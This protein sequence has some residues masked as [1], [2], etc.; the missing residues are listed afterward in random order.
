LRGFR[1]FFLAGREENEFDAGGVATVESSPPIVA[2][3][4]MEA[5]P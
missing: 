4:V 2:A 5:P 3:V 1:L